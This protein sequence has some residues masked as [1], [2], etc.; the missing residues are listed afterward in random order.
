MWSVSS[1]QNGV[2]LRNEA[3]VVRWSPYIQKVRTT[4]GATAVQIVEKRTG[5][6]ESLS[7]SAPGTA[8]RTFPC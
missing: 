4:S 8:K 1:G 7:I 5:P 2:G 6:R 3:I